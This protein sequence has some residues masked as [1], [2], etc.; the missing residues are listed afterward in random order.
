MIN[1]AFMSQFGYKFEVMEKINN[2]HKDTTGCTFVA[3]KP[4][5]EK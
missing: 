2:S 1:I 3:K 5:S 4:W